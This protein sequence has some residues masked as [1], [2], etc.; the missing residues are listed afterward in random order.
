M[1]IGLFGSYHPWPHLAVLGGMLGGAK[2]A[3]WAGANPR[4]VLGHSPLIYLSFVESLY[5]EACMRPYM[6]QNMSHI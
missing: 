4:P 6:R 2:S 5:N 3:P 1:L